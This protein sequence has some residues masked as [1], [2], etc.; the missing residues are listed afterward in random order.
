MTLKNIFLFLAAATLV[1]SPAKARAADEIKIGSIAR[2]AYHWSR[3]VAEDKGYFKKENLKARVFNVRSVSKAVQALSANSTDV[4]LPGN[5][6][7]LIRAQVKKAPVTIIAGG[8][9]K[10]LYDLI[11]GPKYKKIEDLRGTTMGVINLTSGSTVLLKKILAAHGMHYP[12]DFDM[13]MVGG[14]PDRFAA[15][16]RGGVSAAMVTPP[17]SFKADEA[18]LNVVANIGTYLPNY[19][20]TIAGANTK[21]LKAN[22]DVAVRFLKAVIRANRFITDPKNKEEAISI[23]SKHEKIKAE[24]A[25]RTYKMVV[26]DLKPISPVAEINIKALDAVIKLDLESKKLKKAFPASMFFDD[27]YRQEALKRLGG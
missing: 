5:A 17:T 19:M 23:L 12:K 3:Y 6:S 15:V 9:D 13:L 18:G 27:S 26:E 20:F 7:G 2:G 4:L 14:T 21:W 11:A 16:K 25:R 1:L 24:Y 10:A 8:F 22:R